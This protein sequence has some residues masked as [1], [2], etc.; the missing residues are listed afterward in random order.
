MAET[1]NKLGL[2][3]SEFKKNIQE[4]NR[5]IRV[6]NSEFKAASSG[7]G[8]WAK[9]AD[10]I[11]AKLK[12]LKSVLNSQ[13]TILNSLEAQYKAVAQEE[14]ETSKGAQELLI[15][16]NNQKAAINK[17][18][19][20]I[21]KWETA[22]TN[23]NSE[24]DDSQTEITD[25]NKNLKKVDD[26]ADDA[27]TGLKDLGDGF[28]VVKGAM[29]NLLAEGIKSL[30]SG[31]GNLAASTR[32]YRTEMGKLE[33]AFDTAELGADAA[34]E[35]YKD[36]YGIMADEGAATEA[37]QQLA[38]ISQ[39]EKDL[40]ANTRILSGVFAEYGNSIP[41][42]G[43]AEGMA[44]TAAMGE[45]QGS[46]A[47]ALEWQG[48]NLE[49]FN[50]KLGALSTEEE[51]A[52]LIQETLT[53]LYGES[54][55]K[56]RENNKEVIAANEAQADLTDSY[57]A[58][59]EKAEPIIT[60]IKQG[61]AD[62]LSAALDL[63]KNVDF[64]KISDSIKKGFSYFIDNVLPAI[65]NGF[66]WIKDNS[67]YIE[68]G[69]AAIVAAFIAWKAIGLATMIKGLIAQFISLVAAQ[70][71]VTVA[72]K[73]MNL[74][75]QANVI[76]IVITAIA[77]LV[78][79]FV[80]LWNKSEA[81]RNF[82]INLWDNI[83][84]KV[85]EIVTAI[86]E[87]FNNLWT[88]ITKKWAGIKNWFNE[89]WDGIKNGAKNLKENIVNFFTNAINGVKNTWQNIGKW[90]SEKWQNIKDTAKTLKEN[91]VNFFK[92][93][94]KGVT[95]TWDKVKGYFS[96]KWQNIK[97]TF[98]SVGSWFS[99]IFSTAWQNIKNVFSGWGSFFSGLWTQ[100]KDKFN[101]IGSNIATAINSS[102]TSGINGVLSAVESII[103]KGIGLINSA[104]N[105]ANK[106]PGVDVSTVPT[107]SLPR[108]YQG[109]VVERG[110]PYLLEGRGDEAVVPLHN[111]K[112]WIRKTA[113][114]MTQALKNEGVITGGGGSHTVNQT[115]NQYNTSPKALSRLEIYRQTKRQ[116]A[117]AKGV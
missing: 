62:L 66:T 72:Q 81:F 36:L 7:M 11:G 113:Q 83:K 69:I 80:V 51:R 48:V 74:A 92:D 17:T 96:E 13:N 18:N 9:S 71:G 101:S 58:L 14:G 87:F 85:S 100:I 29:A 19:S 59:G 54:A 110:K 116:L 40:E 63:V 52:A 6:A 4:A 22:L 108:L 102:V 75:M 73:L 65:K 35:T 28:T 90:F 64:S 115:F 32:E 50:E 45:V 20:E 95:D 91:I 27:E 3:I 21:G 57:A 103:N 34:K 42:E 117:F 53:G 60:T 84:T 82:W 26:A 31:F 114:D 37:A 44:A 38:K 97:D 78:A 98:S 105:L 99:G 49:D 77:A 43:L 94:W 33:T 41:L 112:K 12:N 1:T 2:D 15:K 8:D 23:L 68:A 111:N 86:G 10:G 5:L 16:I 24:L 79:A 56:Y 47:D 61:M 30:I 67:V 39:N 55:D 70:E 106:L 46:L 89:K 76:G 88:T 25:F 104:I 109:A 107:L 93:A